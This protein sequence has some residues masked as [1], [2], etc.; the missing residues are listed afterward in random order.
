MVE[1][2]E[3]IGRE[4]RPGWK[5]KGSRLDEKSEGNG[6]EREEGWRTS[7]DRKKG[8]KKEVKGRDRLCNMFELKVQYY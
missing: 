2:R 8:Q 7:R 1:K 3:R 6:R 4:K 5:R